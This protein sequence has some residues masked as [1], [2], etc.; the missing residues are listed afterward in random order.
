MEEV[1][2]APALSENVRPSAS[3]K[4]ANHLLASCHRTLGTLCAFLR[5][6]T[7]MK[8]FMCQGGYCFWALDVTL[9][10]PGVWTGNSGNSVSPLLTPLEVLPAV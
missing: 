9:G 1:T 10:T 6:M 5:M 8:L 2:G 7:K 4:S 3:M